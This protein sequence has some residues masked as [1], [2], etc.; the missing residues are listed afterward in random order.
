[1]ALADDNVVID[2]TGMN[3]FS[4]N[5]DE[6]EDKRLVGELKLAI[7]AKRANNFLD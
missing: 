3:V 1:V 4:R 7:C 5:G 2:F 6:G